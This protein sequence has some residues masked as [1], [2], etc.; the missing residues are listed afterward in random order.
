[1]LPVLVLGPKFSLGEMTENSSHGH[2]ASA[3][4]SAKVELELVVLDI[5][6]GG[7]DLDTWSASSC[8]IRPWTSTNS[9]L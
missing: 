6:V 5:L 9:L 4:W 3:P 2:L 1:M 8:G 7:V